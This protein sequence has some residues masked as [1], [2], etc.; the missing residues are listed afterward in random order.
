MNAV[1]DDGGRLLAGFKGAGDCGVY[2][3]IGLKPE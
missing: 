1:V 2:M 3:V